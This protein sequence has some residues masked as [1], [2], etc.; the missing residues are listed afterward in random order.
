MLEEYKKELQWSYWKFCWAVKKKE[1]KYLLS[2]CEHQNAT[3][4]WVL[5]SM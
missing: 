1:T 3:Y 5:I 2:A 4:E